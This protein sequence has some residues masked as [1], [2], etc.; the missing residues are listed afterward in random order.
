[1]GEGEEGEGVG[2]ESARPNC[3]RNKHLFEDDVPYVFC[4]VF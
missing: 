4:G 2:E 3:K 1:M